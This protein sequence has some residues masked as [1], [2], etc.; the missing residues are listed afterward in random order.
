MY[1]LSFPPS[2][3]P[4]C[5]GR[6]GTASLARLQNQ[7]GGEVNDGGDADDR[8]AEIRWRPPLLMLMKP[9]ALGAP[10]VLDRASHVPNPSQ[11][12]PTATPR[13]WYSQVIL[14]PYS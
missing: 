3:G 11:V 2:H 8:D 4:L 7:G 14:L 12:T 1:S 10:V 5:T 9:V 6:A 13:G